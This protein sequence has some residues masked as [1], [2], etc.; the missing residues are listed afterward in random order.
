MRTQVAAALI[1][2]GIL[3]PA[4]SAHGQSPLPDVRPEFVVNT[5]TF[6]IQTAPAVA[7]SASGTVWTAWID[8][9][10]QQQG[11]KARRFGPDGLPLGGEIQVRGAFGFPNDEFM[12]PRVGAAAD[13]GCVVVWAESPAI[14][15]RRFDFNGAPVGETQSIVAS[16]SFENISFPD[17]AVAADGSFVVAWMQSDVLAGAI[18]FQSFDAQGQMLG[19]PGTVAAGAPFSMTALRLAGA[20]D[21]SFLALWRTFSQGLILARKYDA[22]RAGSAVF[23]VSTLGTGYAYAPAAVL[24]SDGSARVA[25]TTGTTVLGRRLS[26][27]GEPAGPEVPV[28]D[29]TGLFDSP[30]LAVDKDGNALVVWSDQNLHLEGRLLQDDL[31]PLSDV[32]PAANPAFP[33]TLPSL[34]TTAAGDLVLIW[35]SG[36]V[37][38]SPF[39]PPP[40]PVAGQDG[41]SQGI[42][43]R[44]FGPLRCVAGSETLCLGPNQ[45]FEARV[46]WE[47]PST[48]QTGTG[49]TLP[50]TENTGSFWFFGNQNLELMVKVLDGTSINLRY[51]VYA[52]SLSNVEYTLTITDTLTGVVRTY[53][54]PAGQFASLADVDA[55]PFGVSSRAAAPAPRI[56]NPALTAGCLRP[57][58]DAAAQ[59]LLCVAGDF[60]VSVQFTDPRTGLAGAATALSLTSDT[61]AFWFFDDSNLELMIKVL[62]GRTVNGKFWVFYG[63]LS[64]VD[65]TITVTQGTT[66]AVRTYHNPRGTLA[67]H[68]DIQAF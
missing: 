27:T 19:D 51:W 8:R 18:R 44:I 64:D 50:L 35:S 47:N 23:Q 4:S 60:A 49:R 43:A 1:L 32:F 7:A 36:F 42:A 24:L 39:F 14:K 22:A 57:G 21:G 56:P 33:A 45:R 6:G 59:T 55:F 13:G 26:A 62:D 15:Y 63:A 37:F 66:G 54:N 38:N 68:A 28:G 25:W 58:V 41:D 5:F 17:V 9:G 53:H 30:A 11:I 12:G 52:G 29:F 3:L 48:G 40:P 2:T 61:G 31:T 16:G 10:Q 46:S 20:A 34:A 65:Y 67:S